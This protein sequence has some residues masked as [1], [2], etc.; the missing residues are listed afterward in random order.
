MKKF[1]YIIAAVFVVAMG[2]AIFFGCQKENEDIDK[3]TIVKPIKKYYDNTMSHI[4]YD[5]VEYT[6]LNI[7]QTYPSG[8]NGVDK[9]S[10][11]KLFFDTFITY[12]NDNGWNSFSYY[13]NITNDEKNCFM[14]LSCVY[15]STLSK[16][17][18]INLRNDFIANQGSGYNLSLPA[19]E[20]A[21][22]YAQ[23]LNAS[24]NL[25]MI[26]PSSTQFL[27]TEGDSRFER[28]LHAAIE[29]ITKEI[30]AHP[31]KTAAYIVGLPGSYVWV[32]AEATYDVLTGKY[33]HIK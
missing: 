2:T 33:D 11:M 6:A 20:R 13:G 15:D 26:F 27:K 1:R 5:A 12:L 7:I 24:E 21:I 16:I 9:S 3:N 18:R 10:Y 14:M 29:A 19:Q 22:A 31:I 8:I 23:M 28:Q 25:E 4:F 32:L 17:D 30:F